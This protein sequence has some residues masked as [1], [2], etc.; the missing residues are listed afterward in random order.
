MAGAVIHSVILAIG[1][2]NTS[3]AGLAM[4]TWVLWILA[5]A[6]IAGAIHTLWTKA[7]RPMVRAAKTIHDTYEKVLEYDDRIEH[8]EQNTK[9]LTRNSGS[10]LADAVYRIE[11]GLDDHV[12]EA[13]RQIELGKE[14][15]AGILAEISEVWKTLAAR[16]TVKAALKTAEKI[17]ENE[18]GE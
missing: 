7:V 11:K 15:E 4:P 18:R 8:V 3:V 5:L 10:H 14:K 1:E 12:V 13:Q 17:E 9:Q 6:A 2:D 16:D